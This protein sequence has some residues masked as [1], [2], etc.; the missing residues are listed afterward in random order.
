MSSLFSLR[1]THAAAAQKLCCAAFQI[2]S[3][4]IER[5]ILES[6]TYKSATTTIMFYFYGQGSVENNIGKEHYMILSRT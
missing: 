2:L 1:G 5:Q 3:G 4:L 6:S